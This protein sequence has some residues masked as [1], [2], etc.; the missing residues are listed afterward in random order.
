MKQSTAIPQTENS[1]GAAIFKKMLED[2]KAICFPSNLLSRE[3]FSCLIL[4]LLRVNPM[5]P[6]PMI[7]RHVYHVTRAVLSTN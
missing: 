2:K 3:I 6:L 4:T 5:N 1:K 7:E